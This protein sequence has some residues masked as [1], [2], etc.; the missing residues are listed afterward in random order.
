MCNRVPEVETVSGCMPHSEAPPCAPAPAARPPPPGPREPPSSRRSALLKA[1]PGTVRPGTVMPVAAAA[2]GVL[3]G[4]CRCLPSALC[5]PRLLGRPRCCRPLVSPAFRRSCAQSPL[6]LASHPRLC[7][8][9][10]RAVRTD[11]QVSSRQMGVHVYTASIHK[12]HE[13]NEERALFDHDSSGWHALERTRRA[14]PLPGGGSVPSRFRGRSVPFGCLVVTGTHA[15][16]A[17]EG[18][19]GGSSEAVRN[20]SSRRKCVSAPVLVGTR[21]RIRARRY[22]YS[23]HDKAGHL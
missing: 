11:I 23:R 19:S 16:H 7:R 20:P 10:G 12:S 1:R 5:L 18:A 8:T 22:Y 21:C 15:S 13:V 6:V 14:R 2:A 3:V 17:R 4:R 9:A